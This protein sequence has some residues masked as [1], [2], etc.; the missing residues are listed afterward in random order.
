MDGHTDSQTYIHRHPKPSRLSAII[1]NIQEAATEPG[2]ISLL[3]YQC[4]LQELNNRRATLEK[5]LK[6]VGQTHSLHCYSLHPSAVMNTGPVCCWEK[7]GPLLLHTNTHQHT[8]LYTG[9]NISHSLARTL[10]T[11]QLNFLPLTHEHTQWSSLIIFL[12]NQ[13]GAGYVRSPRAKEGRTAVN[14]KR[15]R[16]GDRRAEGSRD[17]EERRHSDRFTVYEDKMQ[18]QRDRVP[19]GTHFDTAAFSFQLVCIQ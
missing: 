6:D 15:G 14:G 11:I 13:L 16:G 19:E 18:R 2:Q 5:S 8:H 4:K 1:S 7:R 17:G 9:A 12:K 3:L 10:T